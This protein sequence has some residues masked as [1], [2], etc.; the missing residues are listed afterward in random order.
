VIYISNLPNGGIT[1]VVNSAD[2]PGW[3]FDERISG[4][5]IAQG[6]L[7]TSA[8]R[9]LAAATGRNLYVVN[10][11]AQ[12]NGTERKCVTEIGG[13]VVTRCHFRTGRQ[14]IWRKDVTQLPVCIFNKSK[15][16]GSIR[17]VFNA[18]HFGSDPALSAFEIDLAIFL[19]M[20]AANVPRR[21]TSI[22]VATACFFLWLEKTL[23]RF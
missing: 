16:G 21:K 15:P 22:V 13:G 8:A 1:A 5:A 7:L 20:T 14:P 6:R 2:F 17:I 4:F 18:E 3:E 23:G 10:V 11:R 19:F 9:N 12:R